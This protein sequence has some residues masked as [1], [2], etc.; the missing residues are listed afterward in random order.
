MFINHCHTAPKGWFDKNDQG[1]GTLK[2]LKKIMDEAGVEKAVAFAPFLHLMPKD[3][4]WYKPDFKT[5]RECNEWLYQSLKD[6]PGIYGFVTVNPKS[7]DSCDILN[8]YINKGFV[9]VKIHPPIFQIRVDDPFLDEF[10]S[11][12]ER[13]NVP[14]LFHIGVHGWKINEYRPI[15]L[16]NVAYKHPKLKIIVEHSHDTLFFKEVLAVLKNNSKIWNN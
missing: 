4:V 10:Y 11:T 7:S 6:Y 1:K 12:V 13:L 3:R 8:E 2:R 14:I 16:D 5:E 15:L 9:G